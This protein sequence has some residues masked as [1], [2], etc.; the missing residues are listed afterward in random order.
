VAFLL[1]ILL[2]QRVT[3]TARA[4]VVVDQQPA[5]QGPPEKQI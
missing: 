3:E 1:S 2:K 5:F 4:G